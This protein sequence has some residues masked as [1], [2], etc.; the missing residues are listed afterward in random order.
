MCDGA[1]AI[2]LT[3]ELCAVRVAGLGSAT[4]TSSLLDRRELGRMEATR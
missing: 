1:A 3:F 2:I 4:D